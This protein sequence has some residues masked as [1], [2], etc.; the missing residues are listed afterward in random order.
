VLM[1]LD[2]S[3]QILNAI[4]VQIDVALPDPN[5]PAIMSTAATGSVTL[6]NLL[7]GH[8]EQVYVSST[9]SQQASGFVFVSLSILLWTATTTA[10]IDFIGSHLSLPATQLWWAKVVMTSAV[11]TAV[12]YID[13]HD[14]LVPVVA[15]HVITRTN[16]VVG[17]HMVYVCEHS[18]AILP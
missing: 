5:Q 17:P 6:L 12:Y 18:G 16:V 7:T 1:V 4:S 15:W 14:N 9:D 8:T 11:A 10:L 13:Q 2:A 3:G